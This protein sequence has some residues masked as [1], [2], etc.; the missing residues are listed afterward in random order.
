MA[1]YTN[2]E[3]IRKTLFMIFRG[4][5]ICLLVYA[6][7]DEQSFF[8]LDIWKREFLY[9]ADIKDPDSFP[10]IL[11][12]NKCDLDE[13]QRQVNVDSVQE[14]CFSNGNIQSFKT[15]A[16]ESTNV[17]AAFTSS[18]EKW[19]ESEK[20]AEKQLKSAPGYNKQVDLNRHRQRDGGDNSSSCGC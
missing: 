1:I 13:R 20:K 8:N 19:V 2:Y 18:V 7:D 15:S 12:E 14:W 5:D 6:M 9:Y 17:D 16:K 4:S 3:V 11:L 10:F